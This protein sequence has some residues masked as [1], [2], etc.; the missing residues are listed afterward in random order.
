MRAIAYWL[1]HCSFVVG[2]ENSGV[3]GR[4]AEPDDSREELVDIVVGTVCF[5][6][7]DSL[8]GR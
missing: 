4:R 7:L 1:A 5:E 2:F 8:E 6:N 3:S